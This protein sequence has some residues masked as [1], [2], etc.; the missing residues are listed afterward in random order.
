MH[1]FFAN[2]G[3]Q[4]VCEPLRPGTRFT[5][6]DVGL[7]WQ[8]CELQEGSTQRS[9]NYV[10]WR[11]MNSKLF[12]AVDTTCGEPTCGFFSSADTLTSDFPVTIKGLLVPEPNPAP[13]AKPGKE[14]KKRRTLEGLPLVEIVIRPATGGRESAKSVHMVVDFGNSRTGALLIEPQSGETPDMEPFELV[15]RYHL[16][17][18][19][20]KGEFE[21]KHSARWFSSRTSWCMAP[22]NRSPKLE[23]KSYSEAPAKKG[24]LGIG[25]KSKTTD[26]T[27][28]F[29]WPRLF[30]DLS[31][32]RMG[33]EAEDVAQ[34]VRTEGDILLGLSSPK[35]Y[36]WA[37]DEVWLE[38]DVWY[39]ADPDDRCGTHNYVSLLQGPLIRHLAENDPDD[40]VLPDPADMQ[41]SEEEVAR[42]TPSKPRHAPRAMMVAA[43]YELLVQAYS[44]VNSSTYRTLMGD[45]H[46]HREIRSL[47]LSY[48]S[49]MIQQERERFQ[50]QVEKAVDLFSATL[51][52]SQSRHPIG[53]LSI[54]E[55]SAVHLTY[56]WSELQMLNRD[57]RLWFQTVGRDRSPVS[58]APAKPATSASLSPAAPPPSPGRPAPT[59]VRRPARP[60]GPARPETAAQS[61][62]EIRVACIDIGGGTSDLMIA[63]YTS[64]GGAVDRI[65]G[66]ILHRDGISVAGD[67][68]VKRVLEKIVVPHFA[69]RL[70]FGPDEV[71]RLFGPEQPVNRAFR[72]Q[73]ISWVNRL[74][75]PLAQAYLQHAVDDYRDAPITHHDGQ[76]VSQE[77]LESLQTTIN[78]IYQA[79]MFD[80]KQPLEL[81]YDPVIFDEVVH[82]VFDELLFDFCG[83][84][85]KHDVDI[86]LLAGQPTKLKYLQDRVRLYLPLAASRVVPMH[87][88]YAG[89]WYP[90]QDQ[91][92]GQ[93]GVIGDPKSAV[94]VGAAIQALSHEGLLG[95]FRFQ[96]KD[97]TH[98]GQAGAGASTNQNSYYW[99]LMTDGA[100]RIREDKLLFQPDDPT[101]RVEI[102]IV[103]EQ[104][105]IGRRKSPNLHAEV[106]PV[107][108]LKLNKGH[109]HGPIDV[110]AVIERVPASASQEETLRLVSVSGLIAGQEAT[111]EATADG[112]PPNV[113]FKWRT[114]AGERYYLDT[115]ALD[116]ID[117][118]P[119]GYG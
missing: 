113:V 38:G 14:D 68:L 19:N 45:P 24:F 105:L 67:Q 116:N 11:I 71:G 86:V 103:A 46:H 69:E 102:P 20:D 16:D 33:Q 79:G 112:P 119:T 107:W 83:R 80:V 73:R 3:V 56:I 97:A 18:W 28:T 57:V 9:L 4:Y 51:G 101:S 115:G 95:M 50:K 31:A 106:S 89:T 100:S 62:R 96:M 88:Y 17:A 40:L 34:A 44:Y 39:M 54:D 15:N 114:L 30:Q 92:G 91:Q 61:Q 93:L 22:F 5:S 35:R 117:G 70:G 21:K 1:V 41:I 52:R 37:D 108:L 75:V 43:L 13:D 118:I 29:V 64:A 104:V 111:L 66:E 6:S 72:A 47:S 36:L 99:G 26:A 32:V 42:E 25:G 55:A 49:G 87:N 84:I 98:T 60:P 27:S 8:F 85:T 109:R 77:V 10:Q 2:T 81:Y 90:Y 58:P 12:V 78:K 63:R 23:I 94:V 110:S 7:G 53:K 65:D 48:P 74:F 76:Y 59:S 82:E